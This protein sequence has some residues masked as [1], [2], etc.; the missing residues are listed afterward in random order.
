MNKIKC[1]LITLI[2]FLSFISLAQDAKIVAPRYSIR[3]NCGIPKVISSQLFR[4]SFTGI[5][6]GDA[7]LNV[8]L[9]SNVF[10]GAGYT[11]TYLK[12]TPAL[13]N[14][15]VYTNMQT[16]QGYLKVGYDHYLSDNQFVSFSVNAGYGYSSYQGIKYLNDSLKNRVPT[17]FNSS[18]VEPQIGFYMVNDDGI[19]LGLNLGYNFNF[20]KFDSRAPVTDKWL[21][22]NNSLSNKWDISA[23]K[24]SLGLYYGFGKK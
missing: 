21:T 9:F 4:N 17:Y 13:S 8:K 22:N 11:Y 1:T 10:V 2:V 7:N 14:L 6:F 15:G 3:F 5:V 20:Y 24:L 12:T 23:I 16:Q 19:A 18:F